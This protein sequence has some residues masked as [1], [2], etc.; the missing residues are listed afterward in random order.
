MDTYFFYPD[1]ELGQQITLPEEEAKH[2]KTLR[3]REGDFLD[4]V[5]GKGILAKGKVLSPNVKNSL[6]EITQIVSTEAKRPF[7]IHVAVAATKSSDRIEWFLE[8]A[9]EIGIDEISFIETSRSEYNHLKSDR[10]VKKSIA[11][12]KQSLRATLPRINPPKEFKDF[13]KKYHS[14]RKNQ[15]KHGEETLEIQRF[16]A[17]TPTDTNAVLE[18]CATKNAYYLVLIGSEGGFSPEEVHQAQQSGFECVSLGEYRLRTETAA[19]YSCM[20]LNS[21]N[22]K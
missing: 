17:Y 15:T 6:I 11:A 3:V 18:N 13:I 8:K 20:A 5:N 22:R 7:Y 12:I 10:L 4:I 9:I 16:I 2:L 14:D 1:L 21:L 19:L